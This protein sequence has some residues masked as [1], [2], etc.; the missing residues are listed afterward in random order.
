MAD[1]DECFGGIRPDSDSGSSGNCGG[2]GDNESW[3]PNSRAKKIFK[4]CCWTIYFGSLLS[5]ALLG[6]WGVFGTILI[7]SLLALMIRFI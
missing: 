4:I 7:F 2:G 1:Y 5:S 6:W 3:R